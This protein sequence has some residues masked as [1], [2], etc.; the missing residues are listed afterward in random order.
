MLKNYFKI[1]IRNLHKQK[2]FTTI[3]IFGLAIGLAGSLIIAVFVWN[4]LSYESMHKKSDRIYRIAA[5]FGKGDQ[6]MMLAGAMR[7][8][9]PALKSELSEVE[10]YTRLRF[11]D[12]AKIIIDNDE[13]IVP[14]LFLSDA[15]IFN[16]FDLKIIKGNY[17]VSLNEVN[18]AFISEAFA[19]NLFGNVNS[20]NKTILYNDTTPIKIAGV[21][22]NVKGNT[23]I[24]ADLIISYKTLEAIDKQENSWG[25]FGQ[26]LTYVLLNKEVPI[27][28]LKKEVQAVLEKN[29]SPQFGQMVQLLP[30]K[31]TDIYLT[32]QTRGDLVEHGNMN[33]VYVFSSIA[34]LVLLIAC[35]NF[36]NLST[37]RSI[38]RA[39]EIGIKKLLGAAKTQLIKQF[40]TES[41][42]LTFVSLIIGLLLFEIFY[43]LL[44]KF[45]EIDLT[46]S[47]LQ[48]TDFY[49]IIIVIFFTVAIFS[50]LYPAFYITHFNP[51][52]T[53]K[54]IEKIQSNKMG[55]RKILVV[56]QFV[57]SIFLIF[58]T[59]VIFQQLNYVKNGDLGF[60]KEN[61]ILVHYSPH[62]ENAVTRY[63]TFKTK[64]LSESSILGVSG[65]YTLPGIN[66]N[67]QRTIRVKGATDDEQKV[68][69]SIGVDF[70]FTETMK[71]KVIAGRSFSK[72]FSTDA[73]SSVIL[74]Q[75]AVKELG[76][77]NPIGTEV[78]VPQGENNSSAY[79]QIIGVVSDFHIESFKK[80][81][82]PVVLYINPERFYTIAVRI[83]KRNTKTA[84]AKVAG[85]WNQI[86]PEEEFNYQFLVDKY[87]GLYS[88]ED[89]ISH[90]FTI[91]AF[92][93]VYIAS[94]GLLGLSSFSAEQR[95]KEIGIRKVLGSSVSEIIN[96]L[97]KD[98]LKLIVISSV[99]ALPL[100]FYLMN[101]W[102]SDFA[103]RIQIS[104]I[105]FVLAVLIS[106]IISL[107][108]ISSQAVKA[109]L[110]NPIKSL[111]YE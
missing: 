7:P 82:E 102:L 66:N 17:K 33:Y 98:Y 14:R 49:L 8:L 61:I 23:Q 105:P 110:T 94:L 57:I 85:I 4:Q 5:Q 80:E 10:D 18:T 31:L 97:T 86:F 106:I 11:N 48:T 24:Y 3:N 91:F 40:F 101:V 25:S 1:A 58:G 22:K 35:L 2:L 19:K 41:F 52:L 84:I 59:T 6:G 79:S 68:M 9:G 62:Y 65:A 53:V 75:T 32:S 77:K 87:K 78:V 50:G 27:P 89:K 72:K 20:I 73:T 13:K 29:T 74:N 44:N 64:L 96:L 26:D 99:I 69:R 109:A 37:A 28:Q 30:E 43:P 67:E 16:L 38:K 45:L 83:D 54:G 95:R 56:I 36:I 81:I 34:V 51:L 88:A 15:S 93:A 70:G 47:Y 103:Y 92:L 21:Y 100:S 111:R 55:F 42:L 107:L 63:E 90:I 39:K 60:D 108:T 76:L 71:M 46:I 12:N 104:W